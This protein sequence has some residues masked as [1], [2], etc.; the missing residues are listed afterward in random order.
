PEDY[1]AFADNKAPDAYER[2][3]DRLLASPQFGERWAAMWLDLA[4]YADT[5]GYEKDEARN[6]WPYRDW[7]IRPLNDGMPF[8]QFTIKQLAGDLVSDATIG[9]RLATGFHRNTQTNTE[10]GTDDEEFRT[11]AVLDR[12][13]TTWE[14][15]QGTTFRCSQC[16][17]HPYEPIRNVEYYK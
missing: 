3:V 6:A 10:G 12:V 15:W 5:Q 16:H 13:A 1:A 11:A 2:V 4:R 17:D 9:D 14:T 7:V 8:D